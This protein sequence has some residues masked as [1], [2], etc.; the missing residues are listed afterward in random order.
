MAHSPFTHLPV[1]LVLQIAK[2][3]GADGAAINA[4]GRVCRPVYQIVSPYL[5]KAYMAGALDINLNKPQ[6]LFHALWNRRVGTVRHLLD[7][8]MDV[9][10]DGRGAIPL[11]VALF[12]NRLDALERGADAN[13]ICHPVQSFTPLGLAV[14]GGDIKVVDLLLSHGAVFRSVKN[15][16]WSLMAFC[17]QRGEKRMFEHLL[18]KGFNIDMR[19]GCSDSALAYAVRVDDVRGVAWLLERGADIHQQVRVRWEWGCW[20]LGSLWKIRSGSDWSG[21]VGV[22]E[23]LK[24]YGVVEQ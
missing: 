3:L 15:R 4:F 17:F 5:Y 2:A 24:R 10:N 23:L 1:E 13:T 20:E 21:A 12:H 9:N 16:K 14:L 7:A 19:V 6:P 18:S 11:N 8:G 22:T